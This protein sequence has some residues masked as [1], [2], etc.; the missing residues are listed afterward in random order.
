MPQP[1]TVLLSSESLGPRKLRGIIECLLCQMW[2]RWAFRLDIKVEMNRESGWEPRYFVNRV[3]DLMRYMWGGVHAH[4]VCFH[5]IPQLTHDAA[6]DP[7]DIL[8]IYNITMAPASQRYRSSTE[9]SVSLRANRPLRPLIQRYRP[10]GDSYR[11][12]RADP[13]PYRAQR[14]RPPEGRFACIPANKASV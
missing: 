7:N 10:S 11:P 6:F 8:W 9:R 4:C 14:Y 1:L 3:N 5:F 2:P 12:L 13:Y